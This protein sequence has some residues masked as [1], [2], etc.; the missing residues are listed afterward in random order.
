MKGV[1]YVPERLAE[2]PKCLH[3]NNYVDE[4]SEK[5]RTTPIR[6]YKPKHL[7]CSNRTLPNP[8]KQVRYFLDDKSKKIDYHMTKP[9]PIP[10][11]PSHYRIHPTS[12]RDD[13]LLL[14]R[15]RP[16]TLDEMI[17]MN[18]TKRKPE[19][20][21]LIQPRADGLRPGRHG[22]L[23]PRCRR[24]TCNNCCETT[25]I[26]CCNSTGSD[27][28]LSRQFGRCHKICDIIS[29]YCVIRTCS[30]HFCYDEH[31]RFSRLMAD[32]PASCQSF[33][34]DCVTR[35]SMLACATLILPCLLL[36]PL[37]KTGDMIANRT[38]RKLLKGC[39]CNH[40]CK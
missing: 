23:C 19:R 31:D 30:Y 40:N 20:L 6:P 24:C 27:P 12:N 8:S 33:D 32:K 14:P 21:V 28:M 18:M 17:N 7:R 38:S 29:C 35:W 22:F 10:P 16:P 39:Q 3:A 34:S 11:K 1:P 37:F 9:P 5:I 2:R 25:S 36:Y 13:S 15:S 26:L 4:M